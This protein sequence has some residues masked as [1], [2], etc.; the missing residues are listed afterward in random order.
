MDFPLRKAPFLP[1]FSSDVSNMVWNDSSFGTLTT[2][3]VMH[4]CHF[5]DFTIR[6]F[7]EIQ[8]NVFLFFLISKR[9]LFQTSAVKWGTQLWTVANLTVTSEFPMGTR[10]FH[11]EI[12]Y[13]PW[14]RILR[15]MHRLPDLTE[16]PLLEPIA[17][18]PQISFEVG[19]LQGLPAKNPLEPHHLSKTLFLRRSK[20]SPHTGESQRSRSRWMSVGLWRKLAE[21]QRRIGWGL[22][23]FFEDSFALFLRLFQSD[24]SLNLPLLP[25]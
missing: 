12:Q 16:V 9:I 1:T 19:S 5:P 18:G 22:S 14:F 23:P 7:P 2:S 11:P 17:A 24:T 4:V 10:L 20:Y 21:H 3:L 8:P 13:P 15:I 25:F 6:A